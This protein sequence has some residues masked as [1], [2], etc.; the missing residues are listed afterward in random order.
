MLYTLRFVL[1]SILLHGLVI[2]ALFQGFTPYENDK[3]ELKSIKSYLIIEAPKLEAEAS[4]KTEPIQLQEAPSQK[5]KLSVEKPP[6]PT[7]PAE[8]IIKSELTTPKEEV[9]SQPEVSK[10]TG[11]KEEVNT[12]DISP[13]LDTD[14]MDSQSSSLKGV[15]NYIQNLHQVEVERLSEGALRQYKEPKAIGDPASEPNINK[16]LRQ[17]STSYA[18]KEANIIVLSEFGPNEKTILMDGKCLK[19]TTTELDDPFWK[20]PKLW[21]SSNGCGKYD[22]FNG[23]L[24]KSLDKYL[25]K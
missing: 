5:E 11:S 24:Q 23:Q 7:P 22:K 6:E 18:P 10:V 4:V 16:E 17:S 12:I 13:T 20:G 3:P 9:T 14:N 8:E 21:T 2:Y 15:S 19:V 25:K 1:L